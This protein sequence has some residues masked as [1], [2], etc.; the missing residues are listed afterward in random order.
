MK[1]KARK[2]T[3]HR[4]FRFTDVLVVLL[5][6]T[7]AALSFNLFRLDLFAALAVQ[8]EEPL[9]TIIVRDNVVQR[10]LINRTL[11]ER[12]AT[13]SP[14][15]SGDLIR[16][17]DLSFAS[18]DMGH[19]LINLNKNTLIQIQR[20]G[21]QENPVH[22][23][24][25][26]GELTLSSGEGGGGIT[27]NLMGRRVEVD[28]SSVLNA[29]VGSDGMALIVNEGSVLLIEDG[30]ERELLLGMILALDSE[31]TEVAEPSAVVTRPHSDAR[32]LKSSAQ[33]LPVTFEWFRQNLEAD[34][35]LHLELASDRNFNRI[36]HTLI[37][38]ANGALVLVESGTWHWRLSF[39]DI[40]LSSGR[41]LV[42]EARGTELISPIANS[43][44]R[45]QSNPPPLRFQWAEVPNAQG[46]VLQVS[47]EP[48]FAHLEINKQVASTFLVDSGLKQGTWYWR[49]MPVFP[50]VF[51]GRPAFSPYEIFH[52]ER[53]TD[54]Q[55][56]RGNGEL[57]RGE[58]AIELPAIEIPAEIQLVS[59][60]QGATIAGL[61]ALRQQTVF[62]WN[63]S[64]D[65]E[66]S[67]FILSRSS[68]PLSGLSVAEIRDP[69]G[70]IARIG[71]LEEGLWY[72]TVETRSPTGRFNSAS[73]R[74]FRVLPIPLLPAPG[75]LLPVQDFHIGIETLR[76]QRTI[77][78]SWAPVPDA[79]AYIL[80]LYHQTPEGLREIIRTAPENRTN[81][82]LENISVLDRGTFIWQVQAL[83]LNL[84]DAIEQ[85]GM[86]SEHSFTIDIPL[87][88]PV[89]IQQPGAPNVR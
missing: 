43:R 66:H 20:T 12:L 68:N 55:A 85:R 51:E 30:Q 31:G 83:N 69:V 82:T 21:N 13:G 60:I 78:F 44:V 47:P 22:I 45:F 3:V 62:S 26:E 15:Y 70:G 28:A 76:R 81:W 4:Y 50:I 57:G 49:V 87:P 24:L 23:S 61:T 38:D 65:I 5:C 19:T 42:S 46:Y 77:N 80:A 75:N 63:S 52:I 16:V 72:W 35:P 89:R 54:A 8:N 58:L 17:A 7:G 11:W 84:D 10:R 29:R 71:N 18:I 34:A 74:Q 27:L 32:F 25:D 39:E 37:S 6:L 33:P 64:G 41:F 14:V 36:I 1:D 9:G 86:L 40:V 73:P 67:R 2:G 59:P 79:N 53:E 56:D 88:G 48:D